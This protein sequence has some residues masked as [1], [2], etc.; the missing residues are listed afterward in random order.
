MKLR[1]DKV[2]HGTVKRYVETGDMIAVL[3]VPVIYAPES[4]DEPLLEAKTIKLLDEAQRRANVGDR[5]WLRRHGRIFC[6]V[7]A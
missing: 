4:P 6:S 3:N 2:R 1:S 5:A 7:P